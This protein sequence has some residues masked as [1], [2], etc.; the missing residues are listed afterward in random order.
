MKIPEKVRIGGMEY[1]VRREPFLSLDGQELMG[2]IRFQEGVI[3]LSEHAGMCH[4]VAGKVL[5]H[6]ICHGIVHNFGMELEEE[7]EIVEMFARGIYQVLQDNGGRL[8][9]LKEVK[10]GEDR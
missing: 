5:W 9:D 6:E 7:E 8:F 3:A 10:N 4:E 2:M 1:A